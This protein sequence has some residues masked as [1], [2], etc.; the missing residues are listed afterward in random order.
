M[1]D[2]QGD[3]SGLYHRVT[4]ER[5]RSVPIQANSYAQSVDGKSAFQSHKRNL[6]AA[7]VL[8][9][10][11]GSTAEARDTMDGFCRGLQISRGRRGQPGNRDFKCFRAISTYLA[12]AAAS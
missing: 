11:V 7:M 12:E 6:L 9:P 5:Y 1:G 10:L 3:I 2:F 4:S 8:T